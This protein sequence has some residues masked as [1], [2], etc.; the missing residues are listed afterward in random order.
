MIVLGAIISI[1][2]SGI[3][4]WLAVA[5]NVSIG[6]MMATIAGVMLLLA[7]LLFTQHRACLSQGAATR[8]NRHCKSTVMAA[9]VA[10][11]AE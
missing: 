11:F 4:H 3:G 7:F 6:G 5:L 1:L 9:L 2:S 10:L 8:L